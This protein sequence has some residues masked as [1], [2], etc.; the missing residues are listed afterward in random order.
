MMKKV[1]DYIRKV[2]A[3]HVTMRKHFNIFM[4]NQVEISCVLKTSM[5]YVLFYLFV[6]KPLYKE[7]S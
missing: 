4:T 3:T 1:L 5:I 6:T 7:D 2:D